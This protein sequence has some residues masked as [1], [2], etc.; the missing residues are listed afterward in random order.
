MSCANMQRNL[1]QQRIPDVMFD[2]NKETLDLK[3]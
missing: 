1:V 3:T 2:G